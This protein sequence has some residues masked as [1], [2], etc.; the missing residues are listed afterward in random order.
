MTILRVQQTGGFFDEAANM[1]QATGSN[2]TA[3]NLLIVSVNKLNVT[4]A[5]DAFV[6]ADLSKLSGTATIGTITLDVSRNYNYTGTFYIATATYSVPITGSGTLTM[7]CVLGGSGQYGIIG[8]AERSGV[9][10]SGSRVE[11]TNSAE[12]ADT[13]IALPDSGNATSAAGALFVGALADVSTGS[14]THDQDAAFDQVIYEQDSTDHMV[15][16][17]VDRIVTTGTTD[18][19]SWSSPANDNPWTATIAVY[20]AAAAGGTVNTST[21]TDT[22]TPADGVVSGVVRGNVSSDALTIADS[23]FLWWYRTRVLQSSVVVTEGALETYATTNLEAIDELLVS[24]EFVQFFRRTRQGEDAIAI[25]DEVIASTIGYLI[26]LSVLTSQ[27]AVTDD[28]LPIRYFSRLLDSSLLTSDQ[29]M[30]AVFVTRNLLDSVDV[31]DE[32]FTALQR[33]ILLTDAISLDDSLSS[34]L[35]SPVISNPVI[36]IGFDQPRIEVGGYAL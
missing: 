32:S 10:V 2:V 7:R 16:S 13:G 22:V 27:L 30:R 36:V 14:Q 19:A 21:L 3:G 29:A 24:D 6:L 31:S 35:V 28:A 5:S 9:D 12:G 25:T 15:G 1:D 20:K 17:F 11:A 8:L 23:F 34:L 4:G 26:Y 18:S 33:Y